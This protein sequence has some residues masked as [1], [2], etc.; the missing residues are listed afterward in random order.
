MSPKELK[1]A[2][3]LSRVKDGTL[4]LGQAAV[5]LDVSYRQTK[6]LW[7]RYRHRGAKGLV[8]GNVGKPSNRAAPGVFWRK[9]LH[10]VDTKYG[11]D[12]T[13]ER[14]GPTLAA[15][16]LASEDGLIVGRETLRRRMLAEGLW[17]PVRQRAVH[18]RRRERKAHVGEL[19]Q[20][21]GSFEDWLEDRGPRACLMNLVDD[22]TGVSLLR[23]EA[24]ETT[25]A[26]VHI[27]RAWIARY[28]VPQALYTDWK[29]VYLREPT[30]AELAAGRAPLTQFGRM[31]AR[32]GIRIIGAHSPQAKGRVER[33][34]GTHQDRLIKKLR[35][36][37]ITDYSAA[38]AY[39]EAT[40]IDDH[41]RRFAQPAAAPENFHLTVP[42][43][44]RLDRV[45][46]LEQTRTVGNDWVVRYE[47]RL[48]QVARQSRFAPAR[49]KVLVR[50]DE[51]GAIDIVYRDQV[52]RSTEITGQRARTVS[53]PPGVAP[54]RTSFPG[55][56]RRP[57]TDHPWR[58]HDEREVPLWQAIDR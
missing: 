52:L 23:F 4:R 17:T 36:L 20:L 16:H 46:R 50:E 3:V 7:K 10:R 41:N 22:A 48:F 55:R 15:E 12:E 38:N 53:A 9:V 8:H 27:L 30:D 11:G 37:G 1:R 32:L 42:P 58:R 49:A 26:A 33:H 14:F 56:S 29:T 19:L 54:T 39:L 34:H 5:R 24:E 43:G 47:N 44:V 57:A 13:H 40:Y 28:G 6:R 21:D 25:W 31:C 18:R 35:R 51:A 45:F 2:E